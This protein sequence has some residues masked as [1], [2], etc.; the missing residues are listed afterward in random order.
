MD[1]PQNKNDALAILQKLWAGKP[2]AEAGRIIVEF[3]SAHTDA[4]HISFA[5]LFD[6][7]GKTRQMDQSAVLNVINYLTGSD[8]SLLRTGFEYIEGD[9]VQPLDIDQ[10]RA[11]RFRQINPLTG[12]KDEEIGSKIFMF[13][14]P[15]DLAKKA[16]VVR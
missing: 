11:A 6:V 3:L 16:L 4:V 9:I 10:V 15:S 2:E 12:D 8:L 13:F 14:L 7:V 1:A 5:Q